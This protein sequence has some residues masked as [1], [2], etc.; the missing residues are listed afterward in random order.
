MDAMTTDWVYKTKIL[1][2]QE[3]FQEILDNAGSQFDYFV[4]KEIQKTNISK[5]DKEHLVNKRILNQK[6]RI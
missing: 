2:P 5:L 4:I 6:Q 1:S 3:A